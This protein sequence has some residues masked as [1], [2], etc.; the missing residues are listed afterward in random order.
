MHCRRLRFMRRMYPSCI[1]NGCI[2]LVSTCAVLYVRK[3]CACIGLASGGRATLG[4]Y[5]YMTIF[6]KGSSLIVEQSFDIQNIC[7]EHLHTPYSFWVM[8]EEKKERR[9]KSNFLCSFSWLW[10]GLRNSGSIIYNGI[11]KGFV[12]NLFASF[13]CGYLGAVPRIVFWSFFPPFIFS[14]LGY[15]LL[16]F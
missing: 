14:A 16:V 3:W 4:K 9:A 11:A 8:H 12:Y 15:S 2:F 7:L 10:E 1:H 13:C 5:M 6:K